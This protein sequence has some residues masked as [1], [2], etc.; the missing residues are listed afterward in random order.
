VTEDLFSDCPHP[1]CD[2]QIKVSWDL[3]EGFYRCLCHAC[4]VRL[5]W[6]HFQDRGRIPH[7]SLAEDAR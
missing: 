5:H 1:D 7:L 3:P 6:H 2:A 4:S